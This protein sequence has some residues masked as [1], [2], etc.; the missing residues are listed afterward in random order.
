MLLKR[1]YDIRSGYVHR[2][3]GVPKLLKGPFSYAETF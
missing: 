3:E 2:L 1:A